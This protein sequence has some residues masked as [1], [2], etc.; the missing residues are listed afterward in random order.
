[1][2]AIQAVA[3]VADIGCVSQAAEAMVEGDFAINVAA[4]MRDG[5][6]SNVG[7]IDALRKQG[8]GVKEI[9]ILSVVIRARA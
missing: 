7:R 1:M 3:A 5:E 4:E 8:K 6:V 9:Q 2:S